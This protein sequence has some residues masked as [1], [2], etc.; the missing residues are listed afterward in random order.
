MFKIEP[1]TPDSPHLAA[2]IALHRIDGKTLG[3]FPK[4]AFQE[5][6]TERLIMLALSEA[7]ECMGYLLYRIARERAAIVHL[8]V[9]S[10]F[11]RKGVARALVDKLKS[12]TK[13][14]RG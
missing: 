4:G 11:R 12:A 10:D 3:M 14:L 9:R 6:A 13:H 5:H 2:V 8:C 7:N 1:I